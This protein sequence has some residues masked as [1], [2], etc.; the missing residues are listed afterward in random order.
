MRSG[1]LRKFMAMCVLEEERIKRNN[2]GVDSVNLAKHN[3]K[4]RNSVSMHAPKNEEKGK[5]VARPLVE[6]D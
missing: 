3:K 2:G 1:H 4:K 5:G 6:K